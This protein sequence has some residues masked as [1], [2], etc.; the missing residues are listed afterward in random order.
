MKL[1]RLNQEGFTIS[2]LVIVLVMTSLL[3]GVIMMFVFYFWK[4]SYVLDYSQDSLVQRL[5]VNDFLRDSIGTSAGLINQ[6]GL[7]DA[8][9]NLP[10]PA[11]PSNL[12]WKPLHAVPGNYPIS[13][14]GSAVPLIYYRKF[15]V[16]GQGAF[17]M[18]G[19]Q[20]YEDEYVLYLDSNTK[21]MML[22]TLANPNAANNKAKTSCPPSVAD[23]NCPADKTLINDIKSV[24][25]RYFSRSGNL[26]DWTSVWDPDINSYAGPDLA[27]AE[28]VELTINVERLAFYSTNRNTINS[29][30][31]RIALRNY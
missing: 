2:E 8:H 16:N 30:I 20:P 9:T 31:I 19:V 7:A 4:Y 1:K 28:V 18:N 24:D 22:R 3:M 13:N 17:I 23:N 26:I 27:N 5:N 6:N 10:D 29:T 21:Q 14:N 12:Y 15:S 11:I 25:I